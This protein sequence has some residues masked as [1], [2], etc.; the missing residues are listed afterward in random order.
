MNSRVEISKDSKS[1]PS[2]DHVC[3]FLGQ[4]DNFDFFLAQI[5][6]KIHLGLEIQKTNVGIRISILEIS[7]V[8]IFRQNKQLWLFRSKF[9][10]KWILGPEFQKSKYRFKITTSKRPCVPIFSQNKQLWTFQPKFEEIAQL[11]AIFWF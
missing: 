2:R 9:A 8:P 6:P 4:T 10:Q 7:C 5:C 3:K 11:R 1:A